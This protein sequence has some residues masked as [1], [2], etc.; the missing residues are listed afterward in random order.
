M[1]RSN[2]MQPVQDEALKNPKTELENIAAS[3]E[4][5]HRENC[6]QF[7]RK[8]SGGLYLASQTVIEE[9]CSTWR[10]PEIYVEFLSRFSP[11]HDVG[12]FEIDIL[13]ADRVMAAQP[14]DP[15]WNTEFQRM[16]LAVAGEPWIIIARSN[17][18]DYTLRLEQSDHNDTTVYLVDHDF[19]DLY[20][21][22]TW[23]VQSSSFLEFLK[24]YIDGSE[25][26]NQAMD[27]VKDLQ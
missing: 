22:S 14:K 10:L 21:D 24:F 7:G 6:E 1:D 11:A 17:F 18:E 4:M 26:W 19:G 15:V 27:D 8:V 3:I 12:L 23:K 2:E 9:I 16:D 5:L 13:G 20:D 25:D